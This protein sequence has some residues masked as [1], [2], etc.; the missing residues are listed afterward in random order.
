MLANK[1]FL[2]VD[3]KSSP[4]FFPGT[5]EESLTITFLSDFGYLESIRR[6]SR[7]KSKVVKSCAEFL[8]FF[9]A[10]PN[11]RGPAFQTLYPCHDPCLAARRAENV[12]WGYSSPEVIVA[13]TRNYFKPNFK[14]SQLNFLGVTPVP[15]G[16]CA[17][18]TWS[19]SSACKK[20]QGAAPPKGL[21][22]FSPKVLFSA[23]KLTCN[24]K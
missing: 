19:I 11:L 9:L 20:I 22:I 1:T 13:N 7:S 2:F 17:G 12:L 8:T 23:S 15:V 4:D 5:R 3:Q 18:K 16:V 21:N 10:L 6:Y 24:S 14:F